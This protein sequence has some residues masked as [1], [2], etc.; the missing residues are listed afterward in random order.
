MIFRQ[1]ARNVSLAPDHDGKDYGSNEG[2]HVPGGVV[3]VHGE[4]HYP[5]GNGGENRGELKTTTVEE[6]DELNEVIIVHER[7]DDKP[8]GN[9]QL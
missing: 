4:D 6:R 3:P 9:S 8:P 1:S 5:S 7:A 2:K